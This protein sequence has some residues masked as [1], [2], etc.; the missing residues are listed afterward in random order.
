MVLVSRRLAIPMSQAKWERIINM[1]STFGLMPD[2]NMAA[3]AATKAAI[4][5]MTVALSRNRPHLDTFLNKP[6]KARFSK[7][8]ESVKTRDLVFH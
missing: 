1:A 2:V 3:Y 4:H 7:F 5:D 6:R 8:R